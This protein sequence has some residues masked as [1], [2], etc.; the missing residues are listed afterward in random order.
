M[1]F[2]LTLFVQV[3]SSVVTTTMFLFDLICHTG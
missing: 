3:E 1:F 2:D